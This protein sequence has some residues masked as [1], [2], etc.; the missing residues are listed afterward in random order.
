MRHPLWLLNSSLLILFVITLCVVLLTQQKTPRWTAIEPTPYIKTMKKEVS[1][2]EMA[3]IY[4]N[5]LFNTYSKPIEQVTQK[6][7]EQ[8]LPAAPTPLSVHIQEPPSPNFLDPLGIVLKGI[9]TTGDDQKDRAIISVTKTKVESTLRVGDK[10]EDGQLIRILKNRIILIR[11]NGQEEIF[12]LRE[13]DAKEDAGA[14]T[15]EQWSTIINK[16]DDST[17][18]IDPEAFIELVPH[19]AEFTNALDLI[20]VYKAGK[21]FGIRIGM[22][23]TNS[24]GPELGLHTGDII[25]SINNV[26]VTDVKSRMKIYEGIVSSPLGSTIT[27]T[28]LRHNNEAKLS[29]ILKELPITSVSL[30]TK[31]HKLRQL[32]KTEEDIKEEKLKI[33]YGR[34]TFAPTI[35]EI[36]RREKSTVLKKLLRKQQLEDAQ[37]QPVN[38][39]I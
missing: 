3:K 5:D 21:P 13:K 39:E 30:G 15:S 8:Q 35:D 7:L 37:H 9:I 38:L 20:T 11:S 24:F 26:P 1:E 10:I 32:P 14:M 25:T 18:E 27:I 33:I 6:P 28:L 19:L 12:Y 2:I 31:P 17:Y 4:D 22:M 16:V 23:N 34:E 29:V 36:K